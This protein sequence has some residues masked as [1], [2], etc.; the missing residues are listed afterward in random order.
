MARG[1]SIKGRAERY[2]WLVL[3]VTER[4]VQG[5]PSTFKPLYDTDVK[6]IKGGEH[7]WIVLAPKSML[8]RDTKI[9]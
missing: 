9:N 8:R 4:D 1:I 2:D 6:T 3:E 5:R 7:F